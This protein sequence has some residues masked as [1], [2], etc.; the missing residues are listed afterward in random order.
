M[1]LLAGHFARAAETVPVIVKV[2]TEPK[3]DG[4][5]LVGSRVRVIIDVLGRD[6][7]ANVPTLPMLEIPGAIVYEPDGQSTRLNDNVRGKSYSGQRNEWWVYPQRAGKLAIPAMEI[8]VAI[9]TFDPKDDA[10]PVSTTTQAIALD[11]VAPPGFDDKDKDVLVTTGLSV[12]QSWNGD[13]ESMKVGDG[14]TRTITRTIQSATPLVLTPIVFA[15]VN[16]V[17]FYAKQ[18]ETSVKSDRGELTGT[19]TDSITYVFGRKGEISLP[20]IDVT[21]FDTNTHRRQ[22]KTLDGVTISVADVPLQSAS[23][24]IQD[25]GRWRLREIGYLFLPCLAIACFFLLGRNW[26][27]ARWSTREESEA[28][29]FRRLRKALM[30]GQVSASTT[31]LQA[32]IDS[33]HPS[34]Y[35]TF[36]QFFAA[37]GPSSAETGLDSLYRA[38]DTGQ[39]EPDFQTLLDAVQRARA[40]AQEKLPKRTKSA[41]PPLNPTAASVR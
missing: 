33:V 39:P 25:Q 24:P 14:I 32:W 9:Q 34:T 5:A 8:A 35:L 10:K 1:S 2:S 41:L 36:E 27:K 26:I 37:Y 12:Q 11:V 20:P 19:R 13:A 23:V 17:A 18:P 6:G 3:E 16:G 22:T 31:A 15:D 40:N 7:W 38:I 30:S 29:A 21:W 28:F 4:E